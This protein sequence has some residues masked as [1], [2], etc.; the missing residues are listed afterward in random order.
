MSLLESFFLW[1]DS[2][3]VTP[4]SVAR[5]IQARCAVELHRL[6]EG[7]PE[8]IIYYLLGRRRKPELT[9]IFL[10]CMDQELKS[11]PEIESFL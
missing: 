1:T 10:E 3:A 8:R 4:F 11:C 2:W 7:P 5:A 9:R 6:E